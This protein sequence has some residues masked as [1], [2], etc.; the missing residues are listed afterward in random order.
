MT[1]RF[2]DK[3]VLTKLVDMPGW[4]IYRDSINGMYAMNET[5]SIDFNLMYWNITLNNPKLD[6]IVE[7]IRNQIRE[8]ILVN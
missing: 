3:K 2:T 4:V 6:R 7:D 1:Q 5:L 8:A